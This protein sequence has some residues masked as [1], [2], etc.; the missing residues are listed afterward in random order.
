MAKIQKGAESLAPLL[1]KFK[2]V[3]AAAILDSADA[4]KKT[5]AEKAAQAKLEAERLATEK[6][7]AEKQ[8]KIQ[9]DMTEIETGR[10][11]C[12]ELVQ[13][14]K[15]AQALD[16]ME[17]VAKR[18][19]TPEGKAKGKQTIKAY[20][21]LVELK[22]TI[23][24]GV[25]ASVKAKPDT[26]YEFGWMGTK[27]ILGAD[28]TKI[29]TRG[30]Q[31]TWETVPVAQMMRFIKFYIEAGD[32]GRL[33]QSQHYFAVAFYLHEAYGSNEKAKPQVTKYLKDA[34]HGSSSLAEL[35]NGVMPDALAN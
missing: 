18:L 12:V 28:E 34:I 23:I 25:K 15:F 14:H 4:M 13:Q 29:L 7:E 1:Q 6:Q 33:E 17:Q 8:A 20:K 26:G 30:A 11:A 16:N 19:Q 10:K 21:M 31:Y 2:K 24:E 9:A 32:M 22:S 3:V 35:A 5:A 27:D